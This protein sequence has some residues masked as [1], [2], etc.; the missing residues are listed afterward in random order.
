MKYL[1]DTNVDHDG[2]IR[3][4][5]YH[6]RTHWF[7]TETTE[8]CSYLSA[9]SLFCVFRQR[10]K[11]EDESIEQMR[12][13]RLTM[14]A[15]HHPPHPHHDHQP[16]KKSK[17]DK[18]KEKKERKRLEKERKKEEKNKT[19]TKGFALTFKRKLLAEKT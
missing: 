16:G 8:G 3:A 19:A 4:F 6:F 17:D 2:F 18:K 9:C 12:E 10:E 5:H 15:N 13:R 11:A 7:R 14:A 1:P